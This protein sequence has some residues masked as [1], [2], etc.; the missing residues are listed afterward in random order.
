MG[1]ASRYTVRETRLSTSQLPS[2]F[3][4]TNCFASSHTCISH[5]LL[6]QNTTIQLS[7]L[8]WYIVPIK[9]RMGLMWRATMLDN[10]LPIV[11]N[12][13]LL[14]RIPG[15]CTLSSHM[16]AAWDDSLSYCALIAPLA[17]QHNSY[18]PP[19]PRPFK[20]HCLPLFPSRTSTPTTVSR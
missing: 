10:G 20:S 17:K 18:F 9:A 7:A 19:F 11:V 3:S 2:I 16:V 4:Q 5:E 8:R 15:T 12:M 14:C 1:D 6:G 13:K